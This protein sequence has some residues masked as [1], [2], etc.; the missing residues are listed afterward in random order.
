MD[1]FSWFGMR[2]DALSIPSG[3]ASRCRW[4]LCGGS[5]GHLMTTPE[6]LIADCGSSKS[7]S[8]KKLVRGLLSRA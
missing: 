6:Y 7:I 8:E 3:P 1:R 2:F 5:F 4:T